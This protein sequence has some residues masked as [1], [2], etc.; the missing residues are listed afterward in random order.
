MG[1]SKW[2][3]WEAKVSEAKEQKQT[4]FKRR[5]GNLVGAVSERSEER[6]RAGAWRVGDDAHDLAITLVSTAAALGAVPP[7]VGQS[8][9]VHYKV[10]QGVHKHTCR[11][12]QY[13]Y[14][15]C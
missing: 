6:V 9:S 2:D 10:S 13:S 4:F 8:P 7:Q 5:V 12:A 1:E 15:I 14:V 11:E 3:K